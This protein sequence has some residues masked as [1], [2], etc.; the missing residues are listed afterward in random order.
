MSGSGDFSKAFTNGVLLFS[1]THEVRIHAL[2]FTCTRKKY[3]GDKITSGTVQA[4]K[5]SLV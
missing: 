2:S 4:L 1:F 5:F 3:Q